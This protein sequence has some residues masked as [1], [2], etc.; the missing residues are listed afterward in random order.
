MR[1][2][3]GYANHT[4]APASWRSTSNITGDY[5]MDASILACKNKSLPAKLAD[6]IA[7]SSGPYTP[8]TAYNAYSGYSTVD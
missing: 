7:G 4:A 2:P 6:H 3:R 1:K 5:E 8:Q